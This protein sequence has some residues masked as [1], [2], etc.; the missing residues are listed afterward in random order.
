MEETESQRLR[1]LANEAGGR[2]AFARAQAMGD[3]SP[4]EDGSFDDPPEPED[5]RMAEVV[6]IEVARGRKSQRRNR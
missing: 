1:R 3:A 4:M 2:E 6:S 5:L